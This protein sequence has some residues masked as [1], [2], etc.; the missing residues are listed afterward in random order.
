MRL[1][2]DSNGHAT[3]ENGVVPIGC[4]VNL[5]ADMSEIGIHGHLLALYI[6]LYVP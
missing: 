4:V 3:N 2:F 1:A 6:K 5:V